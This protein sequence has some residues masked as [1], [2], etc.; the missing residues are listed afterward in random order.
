MLKPTEDQERWG[1]A[2]ALLSLDV[3]KPFYS[4]MGIKV[5]NADEFRDILRQVILENRKEFEADPSRIPN[6]Q[7]RMLSALSS[8]YSEGA[9]HFFKHWVYQEFV[10]TGKDLKPLNQWNMLLSLARLNKQRWQ[11]LEL[12]A[13][14]TDEAHAKLEQVWDRTELHTR[15]DQIEA[16]P[17]S[18][19]D[20]E[21]YSLHGFDEADNAPYNW[22]LEAVGKRIFNKYLRWLVE[23]LTDDQRQ[24]LVHRANCL[25]LQIET[26]RNDPELTD[27]LALLNQCSV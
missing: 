11:S 23:N 22:V 15:A 2:I 16:Q 17:L 26:T 25:R 13:N 12:P 9:A 21:M 5:E 19:W 27:P 6:L 14:L 3:I 1:T 8:H 10:Y 7:M 4:H 24:Q 18:L 20:M